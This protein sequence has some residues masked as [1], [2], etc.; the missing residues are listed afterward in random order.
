MYSCNE[1]FLKGEEKK[2]YTEVSY[3]L[4]S[5]FPRF[6][7]SEITGGRIRRLVRDLHRVSE[8]FRT[9]PFSNSV[10]TVQIS[11]RLILIPIVAMASMLGAGERYLRRF[12]SHTT[13]NLLCL[14]SKNSSQHNQN[15]KAHRNG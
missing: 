6:P 9:K 13:A 1:Q 11:T 12:L 2:I 10:P 4:R 8:K 5:R 14:E 15:K 3:G 7:C